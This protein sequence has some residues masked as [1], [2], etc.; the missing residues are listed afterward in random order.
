MK[1]SGEIFKSVSL[2]W[3]LFG[4]VV[5]VAAQQISY[6]DDD[7]KLIVYDEAFLPFGFYCEALPFDEYPDLAEQIAS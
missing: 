4:F 2:L 5:S 3:L 6:V 1:T 7:L